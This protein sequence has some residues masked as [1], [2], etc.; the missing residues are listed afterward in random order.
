MVTEDR[1]PVEAEEKEV[2]RQHSP[3]AASEMSG[4]TAFTSRSQSQLAH[5]DS[6]VI[7]ILPDL[8]RTSDALLDL[9]IPANVTAKNIDRITKN[10]MAPGSRLANEL[11]FSEAEF[12]AARQN[13]GT[14]EYV[15]NG[16][17]L[18]SLFGSEAPGEDFARPDPVNYLANL[19][20][21][22]KNFLVSQEASP[23]TLTMLETLDKWFPKAFALDFNKH[24]TFGGTTLLK[25]SFDI[26]LEIRT[27]LLIRELGERKD[28][29]AFSPRILLA[30]VFYNLPTSRQASQNGTPILQSVSQ[31]FFDEP[32][33]NKYLKGILGDKVPISEDQALKIH[34]RIID[35]TESFNAEIAVAAGDPL[36]FDLLVKNF[37]WGKFLTNLLTWAQLRYYEISSNIK[38][39]MGVE[40]IVKD[41]KGIINDLISD[42][43]DLEQDSLPN[44]REVASSVPSVP[45]AP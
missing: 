4:T 41:V 27:Q 35:V 12:T 36:E 43:G 28:D 7:D 18:R 16:Y 6:N 23:K 10:L 38:E 29:D 3:G 40:T 31:E 33:N 11:K 17:I 44:T 32:A 42:D 21:L 45:T 37:P 8:Y 19:A 1:E 30:S 25:E 9:L 20:T 22:V 24:L 5:I 14:E 34:Q 26:G 13:F 2:E 15:D 39:Q